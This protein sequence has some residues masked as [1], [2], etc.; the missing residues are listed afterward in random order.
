MKIIDLRSDTV[1]LPTDDMRQAMFNAVLGDDVFHEDPTVNKLEE[2][3]AELMGKEAAL[4][5][6]SGTMANLVAVLTHCARGEEVILGNEAHIFRNE[7]GGMAA[8]GGIHPHIIPN[9][10]D[11]TLR[12]EDIE[13]A[14]RGKNEHWPRTR[15]ICLENTHNSCYGAPLTPEYTNSVAE[16]A[17]RHK[18]RI[19][20]DGARIFNAA[21]ALK[22]EP[23]EFTR[24]VD[25]V[26]F[27]L[28]KGLAAPIGSMLCGSKE[29]IAEARRTRKI[30]GGGMRQAGII[31]APGILAIKKM[32]ERLE[33]DHINA[34]RLAEGIAKI[35]GLS[36][37]IDRIK[38]NIVYF[39]LIDKRLNPDALVTRLN[40]KGI[41]F[42]RTGAF[43]FR[44]VTH[45]GILPEHIDSALNALKEVMAQNV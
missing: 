16:L 15:L 10:P 14:I 42:L 25:S 34:R 23:T 9:Q 44:M 5:V 45:Y 36:I 7:A 3:S 29:F 8:L 32:R 17:R 41:K 38:T 31:A 40:E 20:L 19:H 11:G 28:S 26:S 33:E 35:P 30:V 21:V 39:D 1:T 2:L 12:L 24:N 13:G 37:E 27:C 22:K 18:L 6:A 4:L 43:R